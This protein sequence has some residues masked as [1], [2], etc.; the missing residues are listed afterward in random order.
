MERGTGLHIRI[1]DVTIKGSYIM[2]QKVPIEHMSRAHE[3]VF[4][5]LIRRSL[6]MTHRSQHLAVLRAN[7]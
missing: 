7:I 4:R 2:K 5:R 3:T 6:R 1:S